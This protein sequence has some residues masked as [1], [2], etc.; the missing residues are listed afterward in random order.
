MFKH[1]IG[2]ICIKGG[3]GEGGYRMVWFVM[4]LVAWTLGMVWFWWLGLLASLLAV[5][6]AGVPLPQQH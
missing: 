1:R 3:V 5:R 4:G 6:E 2:Q